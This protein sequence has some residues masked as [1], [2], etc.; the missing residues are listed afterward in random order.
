MGQIGSTGLAGYLGAC[1]LFVPLHLKCT[2]RGTFACLPRR[3]STM[4]CVICMNMNLRLRLVGVL[5]RHITLHP[6]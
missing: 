1:A 5:L 3:G 6:R 2:T 4:K